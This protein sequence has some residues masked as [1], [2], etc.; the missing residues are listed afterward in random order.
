MGAEDSC[1]WVEATMARSSEFVGWYY[2]PAEG[3]LMGPLAATIIVRL[4]ATGVLQSDDRVWRAWQ[5]DSG[6]HFY[7]ALARQAA[8]RT[9]EPVCSPQR[10]P[11]TDFE[12]VQEGA[13]L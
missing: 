12:T 5:D 10:P 6:L 4:L 3:S 13:P 9:D 8:G 7:Q 2:R 1:I 11:L